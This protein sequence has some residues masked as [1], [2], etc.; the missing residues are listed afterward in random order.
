MTYVQLHSDN[1]VGSASQK[2]L[3]L[4]ILENSR[5][6]KLRKM[7]SDNINQVGVLYPEGDCS[8]SEQSFLQKY[9]EQ[10]EEK[11]VSLVSVPVSKIVFGLGQIRLLQPE[12]C[13]KNFKNYNFKVDLQ[14]SESRV[15]IFDEVTETYQNAKKQ[16]L[17]MQ[18]LAIAALT[19]PNMT[20]TGRVVS[21]HS[22][23]PQ[24]KRDLEASNIFY[25][26]VKSIN[27]TKD[28]EKL[29]HRCKLGESDA[30]QTRA[31]Y[32]SIPGL[33]W[34]PVSHQF[35]LVLNAQTCITKVRE[36]ER[37]VKW[38]NND[39]NIK[40]L[41]DI[42]RTLSEEINWDK[43][44][45]SKEI[46]AYLIKALYNF[47]KIVIP[48][49]EDETGKSFDLIEFIREYFKNQT[50]KQSMVIGNTKDT[51]GAWLQVLQVCKRVNTYMTDTGIVDS[52]FFVSKQKSFVDAIKKLCNCNCKKD[53]L[54]PELEI[55][56]QIIARCDS[57]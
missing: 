20:I 27:T 23:V 55:K 34:Q 21:F 53:N 17:T 36:I 3:G 43:E 7:V 26:E 11:K 30:L 25:R 19:N 54:T 12:F 49:Y 38:A 51:K 46:S 42:T 22:S 40:V 57:Y 29:E 52:A 47:Y 6:D 18:A 33:S 31:F 14:Q 9:S 2:V 24:S 15:W 5:F 35:P 10:T 48:V 41:Q 1:Q 13:E 37:L 16:H 44:S 28:W 32:Q 56:N 50:R 45:A 39:G 8:L 4:K